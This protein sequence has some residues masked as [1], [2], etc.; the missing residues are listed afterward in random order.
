MSQNNAR[1]D[2]EN[3]AKLQLPTFTLTHS[4]SHSP[5]R[6]MLRDK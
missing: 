2:T 3:Q 6:W 1:N 5:L 4:R